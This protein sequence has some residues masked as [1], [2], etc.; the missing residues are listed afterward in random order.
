[1]IYLDNAATTYPKPEKVIETI[2][3][4]LRNLGG[5]T[6]RGHYQWAMEISRKVYAVRTKVA[7]LLSIDDPLRVIF[8]Y[9]STYAINMVLKGLLKPGDRVILS[10]MEHNAVVRPLRSLERKGVEL[11]FIPCSP[12]GVIDLETLRN[13]ARLGAKLI[14]V[15]GAS[16]VSGTIQ[17]LSEIGK[18][19]HD[20]NILFLV[21][22]AQLAGFERIE[23]DNWHIDAFAFTGHKGL[24]GPQGTGG[25][26][27]SSRLARLLEPLIEGGTGSLSEEEYQPDFLP[28]KFESGTLNSAGIIGLGAGMDFLLEKGIPSVV[29]H[30]RKLRDL[31]IEKLLME[32][33]INILGPLDSRKTTGILSFNVKN[34]DI[35]AITNTLDRDYG[36]M[37]R[38]G[39]HCSPL[40]HKTLGSFPIGTIRCSFSLFNTQDEVLFFSKSLNEIL[41]RG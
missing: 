36:I 30:E 33:S 31:L 15:L 25:I 1:M 6:G 10:S 37:V 12:E 38:A 2:N 35:S 40:A 26:T 41:R 19:A 4:H 11:V 14:T 34:K 27:L 8:T 23:I 3:H 24:Y 29:S 7:Q 21:D 13:E 39:L 22:G 32:K 5:S 20:N 28:D 18:I 9:N 16:N 17:P